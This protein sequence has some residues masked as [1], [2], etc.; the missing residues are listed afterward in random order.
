MPTDRC[1]VAC[2]VTWQAN[3]TPYRLRAE[4][5][6]VLPQNDNLAGLRCSCLFLSVLGMF[7][8]VIFVLFFWRT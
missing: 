5:K 1:A 6:G 7:L 3:L 2:K 8:T 4:S